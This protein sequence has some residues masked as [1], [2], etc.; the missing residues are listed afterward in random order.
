MKNAELGLTG[1]ARVAH[2]KSLRAS[3]RAVSARTTP[4]ANEMKSQ[5][6]VL[7]Y[8]FPPLVERLQEE[9]KLSP[10]AA[11]QLFLDTLMFLYICGT[12]GSKARYSPPKMIDEAW[13]TFI[14]FT[15]EYEKFCKESFGFFLHHNPFTKETRA[16]QLKGITPIL[17]VARSIFGKL[18]KNWRVKDTSD[19]SAIC[20]CKGNCGCP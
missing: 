9:L 3:T 5:E 6:E 10:E 13:H 1:E 20:D 17:P 4:H 14:I 12:N 18:S 2:R 8:R 16:A 19:P 11:H 15:R 7:A